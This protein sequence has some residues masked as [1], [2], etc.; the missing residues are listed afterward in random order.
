VVEMVVEVVLVEVDVV[1]CVVDRDVVDVGLKV[2]VVD[3][4]GVVI[5]ARPTIPLA[6][7]FVTMKTPNSDVRNTR[8]ST[9]SRRVFILRLRF[10]VVASETGTIR[11]IT[12]LRRNRVHHLC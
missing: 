8:P 10:N 6:E 1:V 5:P 3:M 9:S 4:G 2:V 7:E 12:T 11:P